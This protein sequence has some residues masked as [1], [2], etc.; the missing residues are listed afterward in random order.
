MP[1]R[2]A[3]VVI[4]WSALSLDLIGVSLPF[5]AGTPQTGTPAADSSQTMAETASTAA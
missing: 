5:A 1:L 4:T 3:D 2:A